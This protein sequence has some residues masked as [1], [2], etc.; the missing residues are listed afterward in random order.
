MSEETKPTSGDYA[1]AVTKGV[2][3]A[4]PFVGGP[5]SELLS[6][7]IASPLEKR[8]TKYFTEIGERLNELSEK[9]SIDLDKLSKNEQFIDIVIQASAY[10]LKT[11]EE[12]KIKAFQNIIVNTALGE[13]PEISIGHIFLN[14]LDSFTTWHIK[15]LHFIDNPKQWFIESQIPP[16]TQLMTS[17]ATV[18]KKAF[19]ELKDKEE[20]LNLIW[21]DLKN[22]GFHDTADLK[23]SMSGDGLLAKRTTKLGQEFLL[24]ISAK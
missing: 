15:I 2:I 17:L 8:K 24:F 4:V 12:Q 20:F 1:Y 11:S 23:T 14:V 7:I 5:I 6:L 13:A 3:S 21:R 16:P 19:P 22:T 18:L 9:M 10:A